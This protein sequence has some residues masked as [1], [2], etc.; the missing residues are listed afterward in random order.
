MPQGDEL[1]KT[2]VLERK[3]LRLQ[4]RALKVSLRAE[5]PTEQTIP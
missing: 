5:T 3:A 2:L 4:S 1:N